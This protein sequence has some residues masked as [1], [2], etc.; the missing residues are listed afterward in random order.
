MDPL[1]IGLDNNCSI[2]VLETEKGVPMLYSFI[3]YNLFEK[4][5]IREEKAR[6]KFSEG[7]SLVPLTA[8]P[9][10]IH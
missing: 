7:C 5:R 8:V 6:E 3:C 9:P 10:R 2:Y 1:F 4:V